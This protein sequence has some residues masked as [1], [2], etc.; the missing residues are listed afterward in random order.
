M[1]IED[2]M[3]YFTMHKIASFCYI[4]NVAIGDA[5]REEEND[6]SPNRDP[7]RIRPYGRRR[8]TWHCQLSKPT[9]SAMDVFFSFH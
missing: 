6:I 7:T 1:K 5:A 8:V 2:S 3:G 4:I 9:N